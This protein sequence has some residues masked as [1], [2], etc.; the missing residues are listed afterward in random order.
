MQLRTITSVIAGLAAAGSLAV[1]VS[2]A[3]PGVQAAP[4][5]A[6]DPLI[7]VIPPGQVEYYATA[8]GLVDGIPVP[9]KRLAT[10]FDRPVHIMKRLVSQAE[11]AECVQA[12]ACRPLDRSQRGNVSPDLPVV[13][14]SWHD[15]TRYARWYSAK[16]GRLYR[17]PTY[18]EW[19]HAAG[20][21]YTEELRVD[22]YDPDNPAQRWLAEYALETQ[23]KL[24]ADAAP[25]PFGHFGTN[26]AGV[27]DIGGNVWEWTDTCHVRQY[28]DADGNAVLPPNENCGV[29]VVAGSHYSLITDFIRD[30]KGGACSVGIPPA[31]LGIRLVLDTES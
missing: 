6:A 14:V 5:A 13:G 31:N 4:A 24:S 21:A 10:T 28:L 20:D 17:L 8:E 3:P 1:F 16:T 30:P 22:I 2:V 27:Q 7:A 11:Y 23:R 12:E 19:V 25:K 29:R 9:P 18:A 15:A 26:A